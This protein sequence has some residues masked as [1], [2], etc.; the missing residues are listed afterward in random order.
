VPKLMEEMNEVMET[1][2]N[3]MQDFKTRGQGQ[4]SQSEAVEGIYFVDTMI[5]GM[6]ITSLVDT[7]ETHNFA[8][9]RAAKSLY[10]KLER[11]NGTC[12]V[13]KSTTMLVTGIVVQHH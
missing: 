5:S 10:R 8:S 1:L 3:R 4:F 11:C 13:L 7:G 6:K 12:K 2:V 9:E